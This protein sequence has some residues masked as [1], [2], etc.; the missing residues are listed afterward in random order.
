MLQKKNTFICN[1]EKSKDKIE[2]SQNICLKSKSSCKS[3]RPSFS[4]VFYKCWSS[5]SQVLV[6]SCDSN[7]VS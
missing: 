2:Y 6:K 1:R 3:W 4:K 5:K 7:Q